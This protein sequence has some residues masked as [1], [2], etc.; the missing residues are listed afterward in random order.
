MK[1]SNSEALAAAENL[2]NYC[3][4]TRCPDCPF[5]NGDICEICI[6]AEEWYAD[7]EEGKLNLEKGQK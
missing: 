4:N 7:E 1:I 6:P 3:L 5:S 2:I